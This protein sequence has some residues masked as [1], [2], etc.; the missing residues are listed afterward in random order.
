ME[1]ISDCP[2]EFQHVASNHPNPQVKVLAS[3]AVF[4]TPNADA[5]KEALRRVGNAANVKRYHSDNP[6]ARE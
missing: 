4:V 5:L 1:Y 2:D 6:S 3:A